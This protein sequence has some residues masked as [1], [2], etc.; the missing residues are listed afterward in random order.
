MLPNN[1]NGTFGTP[2]LFTVGGGQNSVA[3]ADLTKDGKDDIFITAQTSNT[4]G[5]LRNT[6]AAAESAVDGDFDGDGESDITVFRPSTGQWFVLQSSNGTFT[7]TTWGVSTDIPTAGDYDGD[8]KTDVAVFRPST[9]QWFILN[10]LDGSFRSVTWGSNG[11]TPLTSDFDGDGK[12]D[13]AV[14]RPSTGEWFILQSSNGAFRSQTWG[15]NG[16][17]PIQ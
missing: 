11:D 17:I 4:F 14:R 10:S 9:G 7:T 1:G 13:I 5:I 15:V 8:Q 6:C 2:E 16:D 3:V 12:T